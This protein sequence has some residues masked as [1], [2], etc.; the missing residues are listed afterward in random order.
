MTNHGLYSSDAEKLMKEWRAE[1]AANTWL[2]FEH[3]MTGIADI[4]WGHRHELP[5]ERGR[6]SAEH[7]AD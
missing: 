2:M 4:D 1:N 3:N 7:R 6:W 5:C